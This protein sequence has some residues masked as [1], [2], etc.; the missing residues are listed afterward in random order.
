MDV[1]TIAAMRADAIASGFITLKEDGNTDALIELLAL[2]E[3]VLVVTLADFSTQGPSWP[4]QASDVPRYAPFNTVVPLR[5]TGEAGMPGKNGGT[6]PG[7]P[8][9]CRSNRHRHI[10]RRPHNR[11]AFFGRICRKKGWRGRRTPRGW[12]VV[13]LVENLFL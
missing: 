4:V 1:V 9:C 13:S 5:P 2:P 7:L 3:S 8:K 12:I 6:P 10:W 11:R